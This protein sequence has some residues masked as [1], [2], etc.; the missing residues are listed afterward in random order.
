M[1]IAFRDN[2]MA[3]GECSICIILASRPDRQMNKH[4][5]HDQ[6]GNVTWTNVPDRQVSDL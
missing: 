2:N 3:T 5:D 4:C 6:A 1:K